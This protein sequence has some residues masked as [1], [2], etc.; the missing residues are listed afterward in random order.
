MHNTDHRQEHSIM[1]STRLSPSF[2][3]TSALHYVSEHLHWHRRDGTSDWQGPPGSLITGIVGGG[4][5]PLAEGT[6]AGRIGIHEA[7][8]IPAISYVYIAYY[9]FKGY[10]VVQGKPQRR[11]Q[12]R[13]RQHRLR[14]SRYSGRAMKTPSTT[15]VAPQRKCKDGRRFGGK[16]L[17][18][19][20]LL[21]CSHQAYSPPVRAS[22]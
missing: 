19:C 12:C 16:C 18:I 22:A 14:R 7:L 3:V 15:I 9:G 13:G 5:V 1:S 21:L 17:K 2:K 4:L 10:V 8:I 11:Q 20:S 6:L